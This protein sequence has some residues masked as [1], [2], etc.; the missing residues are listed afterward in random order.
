M[1]IPSYFS[2]IIKNYG[3]I[4]R[5]LVDISFQP[6]SHLF[7]DCNS[8][9]YD[10][11]RSL[12]TEDE[13]LFEGNMHETLE[14]KIIEKVVKHISDYIFY[15]KPT[16]LVYIAFDGVAPFAKME[17]QRIRRHKN[18]PTSSS[19]WSTSNITPGKNFMKKL[20]AM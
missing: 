15:I 13:L 7:M 11:V 5:N 12:E 4:I 17:Q 10:A 2:Y 18:Q 14:K 1:G 6:F 16:D 20:L 19:K 9:I 8:I 3:H